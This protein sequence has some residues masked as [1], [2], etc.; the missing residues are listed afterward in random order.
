MFRALRGPAAALAAEG[1]G[2]L[3]GR[4]FAGACPDFGQRN[5]S[6]ARDMRGGEIPGAAVIDQLETVRIGGESR[7]RQHPGYQNTSTLSA[8]SVACAG[9]SMVERV[10]PSIMSPS[11]RPRASIQVPHISTRPLADS[12]RR[13]IRSRL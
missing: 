1:H 2:G 9:S 4:K 12:T 3:A 10:G 7:Q 8:A 13:N 11:A 5:V 6:R